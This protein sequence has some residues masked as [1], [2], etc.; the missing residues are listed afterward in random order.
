MLTNGQ[1][2]NLRKA[3]ANYL[4]TDTKLSKTKLSKMIKSGGFPGRLLGPLLE[5]GLPLIKSV[6]KPLAKSVLIPSGLTAAD[7]GIHKTILGSGHNNPSS[8]TLIISNNEMEDIIKIAKSPE[9][10]GLLLKGVSEAI[11]NEA[12]EQKGGFLSVIRYI[13]C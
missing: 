2:A 12:K 11:Q 5:T 8:T 9:G 6:I 13:R 1:V 4:S 10:S 3:F 7:A